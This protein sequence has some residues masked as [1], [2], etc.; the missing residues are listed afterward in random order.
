M[1]IVQNFIKEQFND[2]DEYYEPKEEK[3]NREVSHLKKELDELKFYQELERTEYEDM[4][5]KLYN[6]ENKKNKKSSGNTVANQTT[7]TPPAATATA[8]E[9]RGSN[10]DIFGSLSGDSNGQTAVLLLKLKKREDELARLEKK[11]KTETDPKEFGK[12]MHKL[13]KTKNEEIEE[14][15]THYKGLMEQ[16]A[17]QIQKSSERHDDEI[18]KNTNLRETMEEMRQDMASREQDLEE[19]LLEME[20]VLKKTE[21]KTFKLEQKLAMA[22]ENLANNQVKLSQATEVKDEAEKRMREVEEDFEDER[23][24]MISTFEKGKD[25]IKAEG[26]KVQDDYQVEIQDLREQLH[27]ISEKLDIEK[28]AHEESVARTREAQSL[29]QRKGLEF[30]VI[31]RDA[32][33][34]EKEANLQKTKTEMKLAKVEGDCQRQLDEFNERIKRIVTDKIALKDNLKEA[35]A[36]AFAADKKAGLMSDST[37]QKNG[38]LRRKNLELESVQLEL[39]NLCDRHIKDIKFR[40]LQ[41]VRERKKWNASDQTL[42]KQLEDLKSSPAYQRVLLSRSPNLH[43][44]QASE[45]QL[46]E[47]VEQLRGE[48]ASLLLQMSTMKERSTRDFRKLE[49]KIKTLESGEPKEEPLYSNVKRSITTFG[50][51]SQTKAAP[52]TKAATPIRPSSFR[53]VKTGSTST[54]GGTS[55]RP[56]SPEVATAPTPAPKLELVKAPAATLE[57]KSLSNSAY[58]RQLR[59]RK[60]NKSSE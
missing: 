45:N 21:H 3:T 9:S 48:K 44:E 31:C 30:E 51:P 39:R 37:A 49:K 7:F 8:D 24:E 13:E 53:Y 1:D 6:M 18:K 16:L 12:R 34:A 47:M 55:I 33:E 42:K 43:A 60:F 50:A 2:D 25:F 54:L 52:K 40:D 56:E 36:R 17:K 28:R 10:E 22:E 23:R 38:A 5:R 32:K 59:Q 14:I 20:A 11:F 15:K 41:F 27:A 26:G 58:R 46:R 57:R 4:K 19:K 35:D 29:V